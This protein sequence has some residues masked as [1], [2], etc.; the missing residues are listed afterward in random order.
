MKLLVLGD[1]HVCIYNHKHIFS[2]LFEEITIH[3]CDSDNYHRVGQFKPYLLHTIANKGDVLLKDYIQTYSDYDYV[4]LVFGE[5][6]VRIHF[7]KQINI[8]HR[9]ENEVIRTLSESLI[10]TLRIIVPPSMKVIIR[11]ILPTRE[12]SMFNVEANKYIPQGTLEERIR[13]TNRLNETLKSECMKHNMFFFENI[14]KNELINQKGELADEYC[15][16]TTHYNINSLPI[17]QKEIQENFNTI[18]HTT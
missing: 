16:G 15:D 6:D 7:H 14:Y 18:L 2:N 10:N 8:L 5:P 1:S 13:Y 11:Y 3:H 9:D 17:L 12:S 4:M